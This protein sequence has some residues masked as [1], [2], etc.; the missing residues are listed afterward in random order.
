[1]GSG[2]EFYTGTVVTGS[3]KD[4]LEDCAQGVIVLHIASR[5]GIEQ[6][7][8]DCSVMVRFIIPKTIYTHDKESDMDMD[9]LAGTHYPGWCPCGVKSQRFDGRPSKSSLATAFRRTM[10]RKSHCVRHP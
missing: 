10:S 1:M 6:W 7:M 8:R 3:S 5:G 4:V 9:H 2:S